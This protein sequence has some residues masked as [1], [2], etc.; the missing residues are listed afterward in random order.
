[1]S[2]HQCLAESACRGS[3]IVDGERQPALTEQP[4]TLCQACHDA[5]TSAVH[6]LPKDWA[7][8]HHTIGERAHTDGPKISS[9]PTA[10]ILINTRKEALM[11]SIVEAAD[12]AAAVIS[13][14]LNTEQP[15]GRRKPPPD[16][17]IGSVAWRA[18]EKIN[19]V[20][21]QKLKAAIAITEPHIDL[22]AA[23]G[24]QVALVWKTPRRCTTHANMIGSAETMLAMALR[25]DDFGN[26]NIK[27]IRAYLRDR[28]KRPIESTALPYRD[29]LRAAFRDAGQ[30]DN[31][32]GWCDNG[33]AR[34]LTTLTGIDIALQLLD[35]HHQTRAEVGKTRLRHRY[36]M[37]CPHCGGRVGRDDGQTIVDCDKC[38]SSWT[39]REYKFLAG[40]IVDERQDMEITKYL[41]AEAYARLDKIANLV[42]TGAN[43]ND[44]TLELPGA[45][46]IL[47][48]F[49]TQALDGHKPP[50]ERAIATDKKTTVIRA[51]EQDT[52]QWGQRSTP[53][54]PPKP[55]RRKPITTTATKPAT[56]V[57]PSSRSTLVDIDINDDVDTIRGLVCDKCHLVHAGQCA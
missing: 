51:D 12:R 36:A 19:P 8:L 50:A 29:K 27:Q 18:A 28:L 35:L 14:A 34:E 3:K 1:M 30:C 38:K 32:G 54:K 48:D 39:E 45:G 6:Q 44:G 52:W 33:Q 55:K 37:P 47:N 57:H 2:S 43:L 10:V 4:D 24:E 46:T 49:I 11:T 21:A 13:D 41:L 25:M 16:A 26:A 23:A 53:Y 17:E 9:T 42:K 5:I 56:P 15:T 7:Q 22:L 20:D 31:C 40:L